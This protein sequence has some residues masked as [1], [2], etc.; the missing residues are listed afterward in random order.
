MIRALVV[1]VHVLEFLRVTRESVVAYDATTIVYRGF[2]LVFVS[3][4][5]Q[6]V[7]VQWKLDADHRHLEPLVQLKFLDPPERDTT[8]VPIENRKAFQDQ[9]RNFLTFAGDV[10]DLLLRVNQTGVSVVITQFTSITFFVKPALAEQI[11][12]TNFIVLFSINAKVYNQDMTFLYR[13]LDLFERSRFPRE[14]FTEIIKQIPKD[15]PSTDLLRHVTLLLRFIHLYLMTEL[16]L[17]QFE[18]KHDG[19]EYRFGTQSYSFAFPAHVTADSECRV[20]MTPQLH[21]DCVTDYFNRR[22]ADPLDSGNIKDA[23]VFVDFVLAYP[24]KVAVDFEQFINL[25]LR[26]LQPGSRYAIAFSVELGGVVTLR[27]CPAD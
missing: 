11:T 26:S 21:R 14:L 1:F 10:L 24:Q 4:E 18:R 15:F 25:T 13:F 27:V 19:A 22:F 20:R 3:R 2:Q 23:K 9:L 12:T 17:G 8:A 16:V 6:T 7:E 5:F